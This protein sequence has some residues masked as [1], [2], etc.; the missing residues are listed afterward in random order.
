M[1]KLPSKDEYSD[2]ETTAHFEAALKGAMNTHAT[3]AAC[4]VTPRLA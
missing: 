3:Q 4:A 2:K 1:T